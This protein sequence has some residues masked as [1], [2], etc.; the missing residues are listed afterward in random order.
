[1]PLDKCQKQYGAIRL[2]IG[3]RRALLIKAVFSDLS[4][5]ENRSLGSVVY[6]GVGSLAEA[7]VGSGSLCLPPVQVPLGQKG[8]HGRTNCSEPDETL[9]KAKNRLP[10]MTKSKGANVI[11]LWARAWTQCGLSLGS[12]NWIKACRVAKWSVK[13]KSTRILWWM[14]LKTWVAFGCMLLKKTLKPINWRLQDIMIKRSRSS[15]F[16]KET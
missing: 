8:V 12:S 9:E 15:N 11:A 2:R 16:L 10:L 6:R 4:G 5:I 1:M 7:D 14:T 13:P 3:D